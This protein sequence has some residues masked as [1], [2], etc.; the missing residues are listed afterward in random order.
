MSSDNVL[1]FLRLV[2]AR[3][4]VLDTLKVQSK[5]DVLG[6][7]ADFGLGFSESEFD[8]LVWE[9]EVN[10]ARTRGENF[11]AH[12]PLWETMWGKYYLDYLVTDLLP[13]VTKSV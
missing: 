3:V 7:A 8:T 1:D 5:D 4:D 2:A 12:F 13:S 9:L 10:L 11:D 6:A